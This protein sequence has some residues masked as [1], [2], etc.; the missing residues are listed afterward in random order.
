[1]T[2]PTPDTVSLVIQTLGTCPP[3]SQLLDHCFAV[4]CRNFRGGDPVRFLRDLRDELVYS[5][6]CSDGIITAIT[7]ALKSAPEETGED[8]LLRQAALK[9]QL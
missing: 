3:D 5:G 7:M 4:R 6:G 1:M 8:R 9:A 2:D